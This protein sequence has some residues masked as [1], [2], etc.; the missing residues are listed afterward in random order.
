MVQR[1]VPWFWHVSSQFPGRCIF[2]FHAIYPSIVAK[3]ININQSTLK[4]GAFAFISWKVAYIYVYAFQARLLKKALE[5][6]RSAPDLFHCFVCKKTTLITVGEIKFC[7]K[8]WFWFKK[9]QRPTVFNIMWYVNAVF[10]VLNL[11]V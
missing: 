11:F 1:R 6:I 3:L 2:C 4:R 8:N 5:K 10:H 9:N 7:F